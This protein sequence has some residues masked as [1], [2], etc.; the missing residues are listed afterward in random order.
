MAKRS[1]RYKLAQFTHRVGISSLS[2]PRDVNYAILIY[3]PAMAK[4]WR[5]GFWKA[6]AMAA[7]I[8]H[9][10]SQLLKWF[11]SR[12]TWCQGPIEVKP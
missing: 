2:T 9:L 3:V 6:I 11:V 1:D 4:T 5:P 7:P 10:N 12:S 8:R